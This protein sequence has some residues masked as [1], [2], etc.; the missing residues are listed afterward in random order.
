MRIAAFIVDD[1]NE[2][3]FWSHGLTALRVTEVLENPHYVGPNR[4]GRYAT[5]LVIGRDHQGQCI[6][7]PVVPTDDPLAWRPVT[8]WPC[9]PYEWGLLPA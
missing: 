7:I 1:D 8:A 6:A 5:H 2:D 9:K 4:K 3:K